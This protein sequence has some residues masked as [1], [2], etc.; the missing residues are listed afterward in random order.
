MIITS[1]NE[2][3]FSYHKE[4]S[5]ELETDFF[6][7]HPYRSCE[8]VLNEHTNELIREYILL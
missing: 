6:F 1:D 7:A 3:E 2:K 5:K 4:I 8:R